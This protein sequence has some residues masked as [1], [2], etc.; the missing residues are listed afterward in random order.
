MKNGEENIVTLE[1]LEKS[2]NDSKIALAALLGDDEDD[3]QKSTE[4]A[5]EEE[6]LEKGGD[7]EDYDDEEEEED[8][9]DM[10]KS[11]EDSLDEDPEAAAAMDVEPFLRGLVKAIDER[12]DTIEKKI[13]RSGN[14]QKSTKALA[15]AMSDLG[16]QQMLIAQTVEAIGGQPVQSKSVI[17][18][19][20]ERF[21]DNGGSELNMSKDQILTKSLELR[22]AGK[23]GVRDVTKIENR[24]N[25]GIELPENIKTLLMKEAE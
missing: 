6:A 25:K 1:E 17:R 4:E 2:W 3:L 19:S 23:L 12:F 7:K 5:P 24:L 14:Y 11:I 9:D 16:D 21:E 18:K 22:K 10:E 15:K 20:K 8:D 13:P